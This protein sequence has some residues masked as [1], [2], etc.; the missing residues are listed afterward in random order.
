MHR[1]RL[2][3]TAFLQR[4]GRP[5]AA[6]SINSRSALILASFHTPEGVGKGGAASLLVRDLT[7][8]EYFGVSDTAVTNTVCPYCGHDTLPAKLGKGAAEGAGVAILTVAAPPVGL[9]VG[10]GLLIKAIVDL[11]DEV[12][13]PKCG[14][15]YKT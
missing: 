7:T 10:A 9:L 5:S 11:N 8:N 14:R 3:R 15:S 4:D 13:C 2:L 12:E 1:R 6:A